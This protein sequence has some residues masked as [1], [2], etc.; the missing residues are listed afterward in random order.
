MQK[1]NHLLP[2][3]LNSRPLAADEVARRLRAGWQCVRFEH[4]LSF[5]LATVR[6]QSGIHLTRDWR[7]RC[8]R[9]FGYT[10]AAVVLG[11]WGIPWG[12]VWTLRAFWTNLTGGV[13]VTAEVLAAIE[14][15][16]TDMAGDPS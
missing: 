8:L 14:T 2:E 16:S 6:R 11:P 9:G 5:L 10:A 13:D 12:P 15:A 7:S 4:C 1:K 3:L